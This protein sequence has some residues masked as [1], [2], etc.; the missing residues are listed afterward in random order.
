MFSLGLDIGSSSV[1]AALT[2]TN[3]GKK[4]A[5]VQEPKDEMEMISVQSSWAEQDPNHWWKI[6]C[7]AIKKLL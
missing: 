4:I 1:K 3:T 2:E 6:V 7:I 5:F